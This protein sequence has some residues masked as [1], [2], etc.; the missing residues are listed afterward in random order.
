MSSLFTLRNPN[1]KKLVAYSKDLRN[2]NSIGGLLAWDQETY[3][4]SKGAYARACQMETLS[5]LQ[6]EKAT[7]K[8]LGS[9]LVQLQEDISLSPSDFT[10]S[11]KALVKLMQRDYL[12]AT[13]LS[14]KLV[15]ALSK[16][17]SLSLEMWKHARNQNAFSFFEASLARMVELKREVAY[18][19]GFTQSPYDA[20]LSEYEDGLDTKTVAKVFDTLLPVL[21]PLAAKLRDKTVSWDEGVFQKTYDEKILWSVTLKLLAKLGFDLESGRQDQSTHPFTVGISAQDVRLTTRVLS[22]QPVSTILSS[23]HEAGHGMYEQGVSL[24]LTQTRLGQIDSLVIHESQSRF[25]ENMIGKSQEFWEYFFPVLYAAFPKQLAG[26]TDH[27]AWKEV[28]IVRPSLIRVDADEVTYHFHIAI[29]FLIERQLIEGALLAKDVPEMWRTLYKKYLNVDVPDDLHGAL[30][31]IHWSQGL[32][33]Y[34]PT[35]SL[36][37]FLS[38]QIFDT[39]EKSHADLKKDIKTGSFDPVRK[40][41]GQE[42]HQH[43]QSY[44]SDEV[45]TRVTGMSLSP[46]SFIRYIK[47]KFD[48]V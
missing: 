6:Y 32:I 43:G 15:G 28:N 36:G 2:L 12:L 27:E 3:L 25:F 13:K 37:S 23:V 4:P 29:R 30:Q 24:D 1:I 31:D 35:Y 33:G 14:K 5:T 18:A 10:I 17:T 44:S 46:D 47:H 19:Y 48:L 34:F 9:L 7:T 11:D 40:W 16:H 42:I 45:A 21:T 38:V 20:L 39:L 26:I 41:L 8:R 22:T